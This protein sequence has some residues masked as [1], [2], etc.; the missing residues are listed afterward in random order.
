MQK[1]GAYVP[2]MCVHT[3]TCT[4]LIRGKG[5]NENEFCHTMSSLWLEEKTK[6]NTHRNIPHCQITHNA[7]AHAR[8]M[9]LQR[10]HVAVC[11]VVTAA[12]AMCVC[13][14][15]FSMIIAVNYVAKW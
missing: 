4:L 1:S 13:V 15:H 11:N 14:F 10:V 5:S 7:Y 12:Q 2:R 3:C 9:C 6:Q 8:G